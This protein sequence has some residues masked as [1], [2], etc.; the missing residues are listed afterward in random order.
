MQ[1]YDTLFMRVAVK[2]MDYEEAD[3]R[4]KEVNERAE[5]AKQVYEMA[6]GSGGNESLRDKLIDVMYENEQLKVLNFVKY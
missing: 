5:I 1:E 2:Q 4:I 6:K 3:E